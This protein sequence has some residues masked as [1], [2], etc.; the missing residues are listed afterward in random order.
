MNITNQARPTQN[1]TAPQRMNWPGSLNLRLGLVAT[2]ISQADPDIRWPTISENTPR[3][4]DVRKSHPKVSINR[5][6]YL[7]ARCYSVDRE[8]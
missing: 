3:L 4:D 6:H 8:N 7:G 2:T 5:I 1:A